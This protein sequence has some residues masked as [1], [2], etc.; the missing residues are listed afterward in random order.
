MSNV[1]TRTFSFYY[2]IP[3]CV[4]EILMSFLDEANEILERVKGNPL[5]IDERKNLSIELASLMLQEASHSITS[6]EK[7]VQKQLSRLMDDPSGKAFT[8]AMTDQA[9]RSKSH[10]RVADQMI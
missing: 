7:K 5:H 4:I 3:Y 6:E 9:F 1:S 10:K 8:T 2:L